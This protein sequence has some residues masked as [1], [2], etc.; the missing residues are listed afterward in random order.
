MRNELG[1]EIPLEVVKKAEELGCIKRYDRL[2]NTYAYKYVYKKGHYG[3]K[4]PASSIGGNK[5]TRFGNWESVNANEVDLST[6]WV[7]FKSPTYGGINIFQENNTVTL[8]QESD[9][10]KKIGIPNGLQ[11][12]RKNFYVR[13]KETAYENPWAV[14]AIVVTF[15]LSLFKLSL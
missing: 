11:E 1:M 6:G 9:I 3:G 12:P 2:S 4:Y 5:A 13:L 7:A 15:I 10:Q 14:I 8:N